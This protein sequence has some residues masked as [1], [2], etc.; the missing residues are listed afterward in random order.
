[1]SKCVRMPRQDPH[2]AIPHYVP[3]SQHE[4]IL[5]HTTMH[6]CIAIPPRLCSMERYQEVTQCLDELVNKYT[7]PFSSAPITTYQFLMVWMKFA[8][9]QYNQTYFIYDEEQQEWHMDRELLITM[10]MGIERLQNLW[11]SKCIGELRMA[12]KLLKLHVELTFMRLYKLRKLHQGETLSMPMAS[13]NSLP[14]T[15]E[16][17]DHLH[18]AWH[19][20]HLPMKKVARQVLTSGWEVI[21][22]DIKGMHPIITAMRHPFSGNQVSKFAEYDVNLEEALNMQPLPRSTLIPTG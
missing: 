9:A 5:Y 13:E 11:M 16:L 2:M 19:N 15:P 4:D 21:Q 17:R 14:P 22:G 8:P 3:S 7:N 6:K 18:K 12:N 1:M 10:Q 20:P